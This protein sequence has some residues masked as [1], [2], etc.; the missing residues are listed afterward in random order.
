MNKTH[1]LKIQL[2]GLGCA[3]CAAKIESRLQKLAGVQN[4]NVNFALRLLTLE[5]A[6]PEQ[7]TA[8]LA[9]A[10][11]IAREVEPDVRLVRPDTA[12]NRS[13]GHLSDALREKDHGQAG[14]A[15]DCGSLDDTCDH[16]AACRDGEL[17]KP[18]P[19]GDTR[20]RNLRLGMLG[21]SLLIFV[22]A[23]VLPLP[24]LLKTMLL[25][26]S[27][28]LAGGEVIWKAGRKILAGQLLDEHFL[29][30]VA[31]FGALALS[32]FG[33]AA[34]VMIFYQVGSLLEDR[35]VDHSRRSISALLD[36]RPEYANLQTEAGYS[37]VA[38]ASVQI[39]DL[40]A[41]KPGERVPLDGVVREGRS[42]LDT[43]A[44]T[45]EPV[46]RGVG[47]GDPVYAGTINK[48]GLF[49]V[50]VTQS[51]ENSTASRI[52]DLVQNAAGRKAPTESFISRFARYYTPLVVGAA[53]LLAFLPPLLIPGA[54][55][56]VWVKRALLF[57]VISCP[58]ALVISIPL[59]F[60]GGIGGAARRGILFKG[61]NYMEALNKVTTV[62][63]DKTGT[64]TRGVFQVTSIHPV[65]CEADDLV[66][67]AARAEY[68][69][70]HPI[71]RS[72]VH[73]GR[74]L[75]EPDYSELT[76]FEEIP[77]LGVSVRWQGRQILAGNARLMAARNIVASEPA[78]YGT[79]VHVA[80][81][82]RYCGYLVI[83][84]ELKP[85]AAQAI[86]DL[87]RLGLDKV[88]LFTGDSQA[89]A[90]AI[91]G[92]L[93]LSAVHA[94]LLPDQKVAELELLEHIQ[95]AGKLLFIGDGINDAPALARADVGIAMGGLGS[96]AA[97][98][99]ADIV[100][101]NDEPSQVAT[102][103]RIAR[104]TRRIVWQ[105]IVFA[106]AIKG[107][108]LLLGAF[109]LANLWEAVFADVG[110]AILAIFNALR[111]LSRR[112]I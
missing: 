2:E 89:A 7:T 18:V 25:I 60:F 94:E 70:N 68:Y 43:S 33:E 108:I 55:L 34:A 87:R 35:A 64:L 44:L 63:F 42:F 21:A 109:G 47:L 14:E 51:F 101:M 71:A 38:A 22:I 88:V 20:K 39:G 36:I 9:K 12:L 92:K 3:D 45:G 8:L 80:L 1:L 106:L 102:A 54:A 13:G 15:A 31:T 111:V 74:H 78:E 66:G 97:I 40:I 84:D 32:E 29:M 93:G 82:S 103:I 110:V 48:N 86:A 65:A 104:R 10:E 69:S 95:P 17:G 85:D 100:I 76:E 27:Y 105:N 81:D 16:C 53:V 96:A 112:P 23:L 37:R 62:I 19:D 75:S 57:L 4:A 49:V 59:G 72:I 79:A 28:G 56:A 90:E 91:G 6:D 24:A 58:C 77:G 99:A 107:V 5:L 26:A 11:A 73:A 50:E 30:S 67:M 41:V 46:P 98:E 52:L 61:G 83:A